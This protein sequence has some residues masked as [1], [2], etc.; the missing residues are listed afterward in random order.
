M[1]LSG[2]AK[3]M[4][5]F[6]VLV[7]AILIISALPFIFPPQ[8]AEAKSETGIDDRISPLENQG[9]ILEVKRIRDR[10]LLDRLMEY[11]NAWKYQPQF[12]FIADMDELEYVSKNISALGL[13]NEILFTGWDTITQ[14]NKVMK[15]VE[16]EKETSKVTLT[17]IERVPK[18]LLGRGFEDIERER[19]HLTYDYR[20]GR[21]T[22]DDYLKDK[23]GYGHYVGEYFEVWFDL[24][25]TDYDEDGIPYW[26]EVN[27]LHTDP[28][29]D[30]SKL[31]PDNDGIPTAWEWKWG[32]DPHVWDDHANLDPDKNKNGERE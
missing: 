8:T 30:D 27:V 12:Y 6:S 23:D 5:I 21:W 1:A 24:Y 25:Q 3:K 13:S 4:A 29:V 18:G 26:T 31:D 14:E 16:E 32:Y 20:T 28:M 7:V 10:G 11:G 19:I 22:G 2:R 9:L 15:D 17:I